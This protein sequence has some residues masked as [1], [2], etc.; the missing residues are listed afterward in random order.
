MS[1]YKVRRWILDR[2]SEA[3]TWKGLSILAGLLGVVVAPV[4]LQEIGGA[5][6]TIVGAIETLR[7]E[8]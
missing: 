7:K 8:T 3:S 1:E 2:L 5:I 4:Q 6:I